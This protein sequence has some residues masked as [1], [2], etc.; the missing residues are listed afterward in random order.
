MGKVAAARRL[1]NLLPTWRRQARNGHF[2]APPL[3]HFM[4]VR[5]SDSPAPPMPPLV[6]EPATTGLIEAS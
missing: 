5:L 4:P 6:G 1:F 2:A 3:A